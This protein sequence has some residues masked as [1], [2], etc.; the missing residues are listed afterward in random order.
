MKCVG[1]SILVHGSLKLALYV[2]MGTYVSSLPNFL[3]SAINTNAND[4]RKAWIIDNNL[5]QYESLF[6]WQ[7]IHC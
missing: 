7:F 1:E 2:H 6:P 5:E 3:C 4:R